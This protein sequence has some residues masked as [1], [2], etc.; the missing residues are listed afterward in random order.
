M[1]A[2]GLIA[3]STNLNQKNGGETVNTSL[4]RVSETQPVEPQ[5]DPIAI[6]KGVAAFVAVAALSA[7]AGTA[8]TG[9]L[10]PIIERASR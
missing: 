9:W 2:L 3:M 5:G 6:A 10:I 4:H 8:I 7:A 1:P